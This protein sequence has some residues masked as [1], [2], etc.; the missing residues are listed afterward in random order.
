MLNPVYLFVRLPAMPIVI[1][2]FLED[3]YDFIFLSFVPLITVYLYI[4]NVYDIQ[5]FFKLRFN[6]VLQEEDVHVFPTNPPSRYDPP[7]GYR[8]ILKKKYNP[9]IQGFEEE[10]AEVSSNGIKPA[11]PS[12]QSAPNPAA[13]LSFSRPTSMNSRGNNGEESGGIRQTVT[14]AKSRGSSAD[15]I[16]AVQYRSTVQDS[17]NLNG[18]GGQQMSSSSSARPRETSAAAENRDLYYYVG[19]EAEQPTNSNVRG[20]QTAEDRLRNLMQDM[21]VS[22]QANGTPKGEEKQTRG[23]A[24]RSHKDVDNFERPGAKDRDFNEY[25]STS[26]WAS[27]RRIRGTGG[28]GGGGSAPRIDAADSKDRYN[29]KSQESLSLYDLAAL[30]L[31]L[32]VSGNGKESKYGDEDGY[33]PIYGYNADEMR[34]SI[35]TRNPLA[36]TNDRIALANAEELRDRE[37]DNAYLKQHESQ[38]ERRRDN[39][40]DVDPLSAFQQQGQEAAVRVRYTTAPLP[41]GTNTPSRVV[42]NAW[43]ED[44]SRGR[45]DGGSGT[46][47]RPPLPVSSRGGSS[48]Q[49]VDSRNSDRLSVTSLQPGERDREKTA[50]TYR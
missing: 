47:D 32:E 20:S 25:E 26:D 33:G 29:Y 19:L 10:Y 7:R 50:R 28:G 43:Q 39:G 11:K 15:E 22:S 8:G 35:T 16:T 45:G 44:T 1:C 18:R 5:K 49:S 14:A 6:S 13:E 4:R 31:H 2:R 17:D 23:P 27:D 42:R 21:R 30:P 12:T 38:L 37:R 36:A 3:G 9:N 40:R 41:V 48:N 24:T 46:R 34:T